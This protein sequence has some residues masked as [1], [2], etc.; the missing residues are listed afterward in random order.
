[1]VK[2]KKTSEESTG[3]PVLC[4][5]GSAAEAKQTLQL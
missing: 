1:M 3:I 4:L 2:K 5:D